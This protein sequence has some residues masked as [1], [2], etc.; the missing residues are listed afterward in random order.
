MYTAVPCA[1]SQFPGQS[2]GYVHLKAF[3][4]Q[5]EGNPK[6]AGLYLP[7]H[8]VGCFDD[9]AYSRHFDCESCSEIIVDCNSGLYAFWDSCKRNTDAVCLPE[10]NLSDG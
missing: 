2:E 4:I 5:S 9:N 8:C 3:G 10:C 7:S 6:N 1:V